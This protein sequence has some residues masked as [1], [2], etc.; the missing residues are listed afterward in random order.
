LSTNLELEPGA[1]DSTPPVLCARNEEPL[2]F[3]DQ[4]ITANRDNFFINLP[5]DALA[6]IIEKFGPKRVK[7]K[8]EHRFATGIGSFTK[9]Y[10]ADSDRIRSLTNVMQTCKLGYNTLKSRVM[11]LDPTKAREEIVGVW[12]SYLN[13]FHFQ[14]DDTVIHYHGPS[15]VHKE[16]G[17]WEISSRDLISRRVVITSSLHTPDFVFTP[18]GLFPESKKDPYSKRSVADLEEL[19]LQISRPPAIR[20]CGVPNVSEINPSAPCCHSAVEEILNEIYNSNS[21]LLNSDKITPSKLK[22]ISLEV[23]TA[24]M[25]NAM[26]QDEIA[27]E[28]ASKLSSLLVV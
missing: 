24:C 26:N 12:Y 17:K 28:L 16:S 8:I 9:R 27:M 15:K 1:D 10:Q 4:T 18:L 5:K 23:S 20:M 11:Y 21:D 6:Q 13:I 19:F 2:K 25:K 3:E 7:D 14:N 22:E